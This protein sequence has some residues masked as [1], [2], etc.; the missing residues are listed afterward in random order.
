MIS[1]CRGRG[2]HRTWRPGCSSAPPARWSSR[3][4]PGPPPAS[5]SAP[6]PTSRATRPA[7]PWSSASNVRPARRSFLDNLKM[8][9]FLAC[10]PVCLRIIGGYKTF[11][12][13]ENDSNSH[14]ERHYSGLASHSAAVQML[15]GLLIIFMDPPHYEQIGFMMP[16]DYWCNF[17]WCICLNLILC[18][19]K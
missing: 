17:F 10:L 9:R 4:C 19:A 8:K 5:T 3:G 12:G 7:A 18:L 1:R 15:K 14:I 6:P 16:R 2:W 11:D 13:G